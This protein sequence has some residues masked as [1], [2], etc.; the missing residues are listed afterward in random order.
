MNVSFA[1]FLRFSKIVSLKR[2][3]FHFHASHV[4]IFIEKSKT[5]QLREGN[6]VLIARTNSD[7]CPVHMLKSYLLQANIA[8][9][10]QEFIFRSV[11]FCKSTNTY[12]LRGSSPLAYKRARE[13]LLDDLGSIGF[14]KSKFGLHS[15]RAG[16]A[17][18]AANAGI[19]DRLFKK[20]GRWASDIAKDGYVC[21]NINEKLLVTQNLGF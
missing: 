1:V 10:S 21:E 2:S 17:T 14:D 13:L 6:S 8:N 19:N 7:T 5:D 12:L 11:T 18:A 4:N 16:G 3:D 15:L 20:H 9:N